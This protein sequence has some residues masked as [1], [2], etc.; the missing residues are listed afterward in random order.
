[1]L[2]QN[3]QTLHS[4][5]F[6]SF[7]ALTSSGQMYAYLDEELRRCGIGMVSTKQWAPLLDWQ[8]FFQL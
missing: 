1:M 5:E 3:L 8:K 6:Q 4:S 7:S 2:L